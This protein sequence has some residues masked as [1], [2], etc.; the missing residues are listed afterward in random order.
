MNSNDVHGDRPRLPIKVILPRQGT[1]RRQQAGGSKPEPFRE[2]DQAF[3]ERLRNQI[4]A[5]RQAIA[6]AAERIGG[7]PIRARL[8]SR[9][10]AKSHR[11]ET[12]FSS[13][14]CPIVGAG[15]LGEL[16]LKATPRGLDQLS[17]LVRDGA[18][19]QL[20]KELSTIDAVEPITPNLRLGHRSARDVLRMSPRR[21]NGFATRVRL[22]DFGEVREQDRLRSDFLRIRDRPG[23]TVASGGYSEA[24]FVY[25]VECQSVDDVEALA[26]TIGIRSV[27]P[28]P[29]LR[30]I[31]PMHLSP[32][33]LPTHLPAANPR[34]SDAPVVVVVDSGVSNQLKNLESWVVGR[35]SYVPP[36]YSN[37]DHGTFVA[38]LITWGDRLNPGIAG[39]DSSPCAIFDLQVLPN[40]D[41]AKGDTD[42]LTESEFLQ[43]LETAL[44]Q[45]ANEY[46]VWNISLGTDTVCSLDEFSPLAVEL[47]NLQEHYRVSFVISAGNYTSVPLLGF[48]RKESDIDRGRITSPADSVLGIA[49]GSVSHVDYMKNGP[50]EHDPSAFSRH[51]AGPNHIIKPDLV[52]YGGSCS[53]DKAHNAGI[54]S[55]VEAGTV[56][57]LG[58]SFACPLVSRTLAQIYHRVIPTPSPVLARALLTHHARDPRTGGRVPDGDENYFGFGLPAKP[59]F[60]FECTPHSATLVFEDV[61]RPGYFLEW[62]DFPYPSSLRR[63]GRY[64][65]EIWMT[66]AH[67]PSRG[68]RWGAEYCETHISAHM[69]VYLDQ[70][71]RRTGKITRKFKGLVPPEHKNPGKLYELSQVESLRKWAPVRT[72]QANLGPNGHRGHQWRLM[73]RLLTRH[74]IEASDTFQPQPFA[75]IVTISDPEHTAPVYDE[76]S[77]AIRNRFKAQNLT[78]RPSVRIRGE[79]QRELSTA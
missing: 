70:R 18:S 46:K 5:L 35:D 30:V 25:D 15:A 10:L 22:F 3:R 14:T 19:Q 42:S 8:H 1:E 66:V 58:T 57:N 39:I 56:E 77:R 79:L 51:G 13:N 27:S 48:P 12:L 41:P 61:L 4:T 43:A 21:G 49:V 16:F 72:Y 76:T 59:P 29:L 26:S 60:C 55:V 52:H 11:P 45:H 53:L 17:E 33:S 28:M 78:I 74:G 44:R 67:S 65:G 73:V 7:A 68:A 75:L 54:R 2:V 20:I 50:N 31:H 63:D 32:K 37:S 47:D 38:G 6:P 69:G 40:T 36:Q 71:A 62:V 9:A 64:F 34:N 24:S 23:V